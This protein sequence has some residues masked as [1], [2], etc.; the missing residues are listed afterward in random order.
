MTGWR[1]SQLF[2]EL[3]MEL[4]WTYMHACVHDSFHVDIK[5]SFLGD[6]HSAAQLLDWVVIAGLVS[7]TL[8]HGFPERL[9]RPSYNPNS[10]VWGIRILPILKSGIVT[11]TTTVNF[12]H[13]HR[14]WFY[15]I[16]V[17]I[18][19]S[20]KANNVNALGCLYILCVEMSVRVFCPFFKWG[21]YFFF[22]LSFEFFLYPR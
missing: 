4:L 2:G 16:T 17:L 14:L 15:L 6:R 8:R 3:R 20:L 7:K 22:L 11:A 12:W 13:S 9:H 5:A 21:Y 10:N 19:T 18:C 1:T